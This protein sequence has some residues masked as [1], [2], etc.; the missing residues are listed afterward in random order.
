MLVAALGAALGL[1]ILLIFTSGD[2]PR[3]DEWNTPGDFLVAKANGTATFASLFCQH[4]ESRV[5]FAKLLTEALSRLWGWNQH[6]LHA[7]NWML[8]AV[9]AFL[10]VRIAAR[11]WP[12]EQRL[13]WP[14]VLVLCSAVCLTFTPVQWR[15]ILSSGQIITLCIPCLLI[16]GIYLNLKEH[17]PI[18][19]RYSCAAIFSLIASFSFINGLMLWFLLWPAPASMLKRASP[20][21]SRSEAVATVLYFC[22]AVTVIVAFFSGYQKPP[23]HPSLIAGLMAPHRAL[24]FTLTLL[25]GPVFAEQT[26]HW[27][28]EGNFV[29]LF[30]CGGLFGIVGLLLVIYL[31]KNRLAF[32]SWDLAVRLFPFVV[33]LAY[34]VLSASLI[35]IARGRLGM[36]GNLSRYSLR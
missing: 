28:L 11:S 9:T 2:V 31:V 29:P 14:A 19:V 15:N 30:F 13:G 17:L 27:A 36:F 5:I 22:A 26:V 16:A 12:R 23:E 32:V 4:N 35:G 18:W 24:F 25:S 3:A 10:F 34:S 1:G 8:L 33:L 7:L 20:K 6:V 21:L